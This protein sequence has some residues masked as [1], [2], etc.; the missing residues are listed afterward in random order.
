[1]G[2]LLCNRVYS[3]PFRSLAHLILIIILKWRKWGTERLGN[4]PNA[5]QLLNGRERNQIQQVWRRNPHSEGQE[6]WGLLEISYYR[7][8]LCSQVRHLLVGEWLPDEMKWAELNEQG[9]GRREAIK[10]TIVSGTAEAGMNT[11]LS[12]S[13]GQ[14]PD[15]IQ[16]RLP[17]ARYSLRILETMAEQQ[18]LE[19]RPGLHNSHNQD[20]SAFPCHNDAI[21][22]RHILWFGDWSLLCKDNKYATVTTKNVSWTRS[23]NG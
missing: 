2:S 16:G 19:H 6:T 18:Q 22:N 14:S 11:T 20:K 8:S 1:M 15:S 13:P 5:T 10:I 4:L 23:S 9:R 21:S 3:K 7:S 17:G 12:L